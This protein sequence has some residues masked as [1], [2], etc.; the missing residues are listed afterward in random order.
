MDSLNKYIQTAIYGGYPRQ[1]RCLVDDTIEK[2]KEIIAFNN[3][4][5]YSDLIYN[6]VPSTFSSTDFYTLEIL[7]AI[8]FWGFNFELYQ[9]EAI[10]PFIT[11]LV[12][13]MSFRKDK[14]W[15]IYDKTNHFSCEFRIDEQGLT[16]NIYVLFF[17]RL[18]QH[19]GNYYQF[20]HFIINQIK[21]IFFDF[22]QYYQIMGRAI[23]SSNSEIRFSEK[24][25]WRL[26]KRV[27]D[28]I[29]GQ[30]YEVSGLK[31][32]YLKMGFQLGEK[33]DPSLD[34]SKDYVVLLNSSI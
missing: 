15:K 11:D 1:T 23:Y 8:R 25:D 31:Y 33:V 17:K 9:G 13:T 34:P 7:R 4:A 19:Q 18:K 22:L 26:K 6:C 3:K 21:P 20:K 30:L 16:K 5:V 28:G 2:I 27:W 12:G 32:I 10:M 29:D 14:I 24:E